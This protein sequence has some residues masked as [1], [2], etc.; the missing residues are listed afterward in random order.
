M[1]SPRGGA[2]TL[3]TCSLLTLLV[4]VW[5]SRVTPGCGQSE[6]VWVRGRECTSPG[7][8]T[9]YWVSRG[10]CGRVDLVRLS[11]VA[12]GEHCVFGSGPQLGQRD[13]TVPSD[14][15]VRAGVHG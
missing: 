7:N 1:L 14:P 6:L 15:V 13:W 12:A 3:V 9:M 8:M 5:T 10:G 2:A 4:V 11:D